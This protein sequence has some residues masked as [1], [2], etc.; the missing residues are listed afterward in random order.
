M[1]LDD[2]IVQI[3][4]IMIDTLDIYGSFSDFHWTDMNEIWGTIF[5]FDTSDKS[6]KF[7]EDEPQ[8]KSSKKTFWNVRLRFG[9]FFHHGVFKCIDHNSEVRK[10]WYTRV[11]A[12]TSDR[13]CRNLFFAKKKY[14]REWN[15]SSAYIIF[16]YTH[17]LRV[18][19]WT[20]VLQTHDQ[21]Y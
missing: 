4:E 11:G 6:L 14:T 18:L 1:I 8:N 13:K 17:D 9:S 15:S 10:C 7:Y 20:F 16:L 5:W 2:N 3:F 21:C 19:A 12:A